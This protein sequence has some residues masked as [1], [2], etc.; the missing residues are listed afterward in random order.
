MTRDELYNTAQEQD[1]QTPAVK[2]DIASATPIRASAPRPPVPGPLVPKPPFGMP[3]MPTAKNIKVILPIVQ[4]RKED[5]N[6]NI[7]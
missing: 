1:N 6:S 7:N 3:V 5:G 2:K 4:P